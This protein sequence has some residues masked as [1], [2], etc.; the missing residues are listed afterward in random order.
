M[1]EFVFV[2]LEPPVLRTRLCVPRTK[3]REKFYLI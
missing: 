3:A 2:A 1:K